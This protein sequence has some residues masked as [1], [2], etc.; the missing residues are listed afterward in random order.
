MILISFCWRWLYFTTFDNINVQPLN[1]I[2]PAT[3][4]I[5][6]CLNSDNFKN[7]RKFS[8]TASIGLQMAQPLKLLFSLQHF[9]STTFDNLH[10][11]IKESFL[12]IASNSLKRPQVSSKWSK[13]Q[14]IA[15]PSNIFHSMTY[16]TKH[17]QQRNFKKQPLMLL[18]A[19]NGAPDTFWK[20]SRAWILG[21]SRSRGCGDGWEGGGVLIYNFD[22][23]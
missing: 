15:Q 17:F 9:Y 11:I 23:C 20:V 3:F 10:Y 19:S 7:N 1:L 22:R 5:P 13:P 16:D 12:K 21:L 14:T 18:T 4:D 2:Y 8:W 6:H